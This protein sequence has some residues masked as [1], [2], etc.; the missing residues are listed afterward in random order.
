MTVAEGLTPVYRPDA[1]V[2][3]LGTLPGELSLQ[4]RQYYAHPRNS[5]WKIV[6]DVCGVSPDL[7]YEERLQLLV[8]RQIALWDVCARARRPGSLDASITEAVPNAFADFLQH[9]PAVMRLCFNGA[10]A[11]ALFRRLVLPTLPWTG[12]VSLVCLPSTSPANAAMPYENKLRDWARAL[13][14][15]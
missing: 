11:E 15:V 4:K 7:G 1:R 6:A 10:K 9:A 5:F 14:P 2:L 12:A 13:A 8:E 3:V